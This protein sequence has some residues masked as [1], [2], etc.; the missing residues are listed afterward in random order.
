MARSAISVKDD[1]GKV[2]ARA[3]QVRSKQ[4]SENLSSKTFEDLSNLQKDALLKA[5]GI[6]MGLI[7][8]SD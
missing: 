5:I 8:D 7:V 3:K 6:S 1:P 2:A 4:R